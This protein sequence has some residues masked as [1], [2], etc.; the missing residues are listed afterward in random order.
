[1]KQQFYVAVTYLNW[2]FLTGAIALFA[3]KGYWGLVLAWLVFLPTA[4]WAYI[5]FSRDM[6]PAL[7]HRSLGES[8]Q[9]ESCLREVDR[10]APRDGI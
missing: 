8:P 7:S 2:A 6:S 5:R 1:M 10:S 4:A 3:A 9:H